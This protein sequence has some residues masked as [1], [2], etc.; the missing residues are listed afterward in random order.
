[1]LAAED[2]LIDADPRLVQSIT[3]WWRTL[4]MVAT[5]LKGL[6][7]QQLTGE[8]FSAEQIVWLE[9]A[10]DIDPPEYIGYVVGGWY[11]DLLKFTEDDDPYESD[12]LVVD[13]HTQP[14]TFGGDVVGRV[15][16]MGTG[17]VRLMVTIVE[18]CTGPRA[19]AGPVYSTHR[20]DTENF[21]RLDDDAWAARLRDAIP[22][23][24]PW[25]EDLIVR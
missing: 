3:Q 9:Q 1:M 19:Y 21:E 2:A 10:V 4:H 11:G 6:A 24:L 17:D 20:V 18:S 22:P 8:P 12:R 16:H 14:T 5:T 23:E 25:L 13:V 15:M 7:E